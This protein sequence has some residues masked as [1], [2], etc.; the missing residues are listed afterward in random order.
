VKSLVKGSITVATQG[1]GPS[2]ISRGKTAAGMEKKKEQQQLIGG[3]KYIDDKKEGRTLLLLFPSTRGGKR[4][5]KTSLFSRMVILAKGF[6]KKEVAS[7]EC[8]WWRG[9]KRG[10]GTNLYRPIYRINGR[11]CFQ[12]GGKGEAYLI[13]GHGKRKSRP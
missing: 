11:V 1:G 5:K 3:K 7:F 10:R 13:I 2:S 12:Q 9:E 4:K 6:E 8:G